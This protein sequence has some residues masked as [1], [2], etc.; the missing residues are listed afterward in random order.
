MELI[1]MSRKILLCSFLGL[2]VFATHSTAHADLLAIT[3]DFGITAT[4][5]HSNLVSDVNE[6]T[7]GDGV[8]VGGFGV[9]HFLG[10][11]SL[12]LLDLGG[13]GDRDL[14]GFI[15]QHHRLQSVGHL[16]VDIAAVRCG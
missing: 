9:G 2:G 13:I 5:D 15:A 11:I 16:R 6:V 12:E 3:T 8:G 14:R 4:R 7:F 10:H 1:Q